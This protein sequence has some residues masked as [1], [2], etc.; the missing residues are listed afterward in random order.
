[1]N[2]KGFTLIE[3]VIVITILGILSAVGIT[4]LGGFTENAREVVDEANA[5]ELASAAKI[6]LE[7]AEDA[8]DS[9][10]LDSLKKAK[11]IDDSF[12]GEA[13][14]EKYGGSSGS[15]EFSVII[16]ENGELEV[17]A[18]GK[19]AYPKQPDSAEVVN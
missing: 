2:N 11:L 8:G 13:K 1:M 12:D 5:A 7:T 15:A 18:G 9:I 4:K 14:S 3:L 19:R 16:L 17:N 6:Y 10:S